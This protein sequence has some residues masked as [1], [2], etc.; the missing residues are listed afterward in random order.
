MSQYGCL[1]NQARRAKALG[2]LRTLPIAAVAGCPGRV[3]QF[4]DLVREPGSA[5]RIS[6]STRLAAGFGADRK[7]CVSAEMP[8]PSPSP[9]VTA[10]MPPVLQRPPHRGPDPSRPKVARRPRWR[11]GP[12]LPEAFL[13]LAAARGRVLQPR[14]I[15]PV[16][17]SDADVKIIRCSHQA[18]IIVVLPE[19]AGDGIPRDSAVD[20]VDE[21]PMPI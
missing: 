2:W 11:Q 7:W 21:S 6:M 16:I 10:M 18:D 17:L 5:A 3:D 14:S 4:V 20:S 1:N 8:A 19:Q 13:T 9:P 12:F 15:Y